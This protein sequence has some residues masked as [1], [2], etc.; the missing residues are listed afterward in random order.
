MSLTE[1]LSPL[2]RTDSRSCKTVPTNV[3]RSEI[4]RLLRGQTIQLPNLWDMM[5]GWPVG[6]AEDI[7]RVRADVDEQIDR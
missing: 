1:F 2:E 5:P 6:I 3:D 4:C 7:D